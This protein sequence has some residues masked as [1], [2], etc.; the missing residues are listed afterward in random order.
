MPKIPRELALT[1]QEL[2]E[3]LNTARTCRIATV[4]PEARINLTPMSFCWAG[5]RVY[6]YGRGQKVV[7]LRRNP[8]VTVLVD[9]EGEYS[10][11]VGAM[12]QGRGVVLEDAAAER[13][14]P[15]LEEARLGWARKSGGARRGQTLGSGRHEG[16]AQGKTARWIRFEPERVVSWDNKKLGRLA[17]RG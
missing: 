7:N 12:L 3:L 5:G 16:T 2:D 1:P 6:M 15:H 11:L 14:D 8:N 4:G 10:A 13:A 9:V 17:R